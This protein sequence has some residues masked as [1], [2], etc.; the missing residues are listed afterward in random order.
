MMRTL[1]GDRWVVVGRPV[2]GVLVLQR[3]S[4]TFAWMELTDPVKAKACCYRSENGFVSRK[5][6]EDRSGAWWGDLDAAQREGVRGLRDRR[7]AFHNTGGHRAA[8]ASAGK[9]ESCQSVLP[10]V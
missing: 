10:L 9:R 3:P 7:V 1:L 6:L 2:S 4:F 5:R 8:L